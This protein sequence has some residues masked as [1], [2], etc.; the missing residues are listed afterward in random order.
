VADY[1][2]I[3]KDYTTPDLVAK[4]T[5]KAKYAEDYRAD[6]MLFCKL[7]LSPMPHARVR[8]VD[9]SRALA[10]PGVKAI[11]RAEELPPPPPP[12]PPAAGQPA[13]PQPPNEF[14]LTDEPVYQGEP[15]LA[16]AAVDETTAA[17]AIEQITVDLEPL[18]FVVDPLDSLRP[19]GPNARTDGNVYF[20]RELKTLKWS[21]QD[22]AEAREGRL[23]MGEAP[24]TWSVGDLEAGFKQADLVLDETFLTQSTSHQP[25]ETRTAMAYWR[26]GKLFLHGSTQST[27]QTVANVARWVGIKPTD[28]VVISEY[29]GGGFGSK[30]PGS[31]TMA[32]PALLSKKTGAPVMMRI[33][34]EDE[35]YIGRAR[36]GL[37]GRAKIGFRKDGRITAMDL[38]VVQDNGPYS[39]QGD[40]RSCGSITSLAYQPMAMRWRGV[41]V[42]TNTPPRTSQRSPGGMQGNAIIEPILDKAARKLGI[43]RVA[44]RSINAPAGK[45]PFGPPDPKTGKQNYVTS[46]FVREALDR[47]AE[48]FGW[49]EKK[50]YSGKRRGSKVRGIGIGVGPYVGGSIGFDGLMV[51]KPDGKLHVQSGIGNL[52]THSVFDCMRV[53]A[54]VLNMPWEACE[55]TWGDTAKHLPWTC[56]SAGSQTVHAMTRANHAAASDMKKKL[57]E[58]AAKDLGGRPEDYDVANQRVFRKGSPGRGL[59]FVQAAQRA[60]ELGGAFDGHELPENIN[61]FTKASATALVGQGLMGVAKDAYPRDGSTH[62]FVVGF[63]EVE[64]DVETGAYEIID[65]TAVGDVGT[66]LHPRSLKGQIFGGSMLGIGHALAQ[67][68]VYDKQ[69]GVP[70]AKRFHYNKPPT[71]LDAPHLIK[72]D[73]LNLP[74]PE[75][76]VG[77]RGVGE[78]PVGAG[79]AAVLTALA[80]ALGDDVFRRAPVTADLILTSVEAGS[81]Q[82]DALTAHL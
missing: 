50:Q 56:V 34:R 36:A 75:T 3:G 61:A 17:E 76:P 27:V 44:I 64:V 53:A 70:L 13:V 30:I 68:W 37:H 66:I 74:D 67:K 52:G 7:L 62:S 81:P 54:E 18:P 40:H 78:P 51:I 31:Q 71:I 47:G 45:A 35:H 10:M 41:S 28:V 19:N 79:F 55:I 39:P 32:I 21:E 46:A 15:I 24:D 57:Q 65:Y 2:F 43:D 12:P 33:T 59:S 60:I 49:E 22:F 82:H 4:V 5:G 1:K 48:L 9:A 73:A 8:S 6:G 23:P 58:I 69:Y 26:N 38:F 25:L 29:T 20:G 72:L 80:D 14:A 42:L 16:L 11:L 63:A 77:A